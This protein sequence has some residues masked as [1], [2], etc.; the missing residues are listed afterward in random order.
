MLLTAPTLTPTLSISP[1]KICFPLFFLSSLVSQFP[2]LSHVFLSYL[3]LLSL[4]FS[5]SFLLLL[6]ILSS[7]PLSSITLLSF[8]LPRATR[9]R[10]PPWSLPSPSTRKLRRARSPGIHQHRFR[11]FL[12]TGAEGQGALA[13]QQVRGS[14]L[15]PVLPTAAPIL[16]GAVRALHGRPRSTDLRGVSSAPV[17]LPAPPTWTKIRRLSSPKKPGAGSMERAGSM[18]G[19]IPQ[20]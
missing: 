12:A 7:L 17:L 2:L 15:K 18:E 3:F 14:E 10:P 13:L 11:V 20:I 16:A 4:L 5:S 9:R 19:R 6:L 1:F 8:P